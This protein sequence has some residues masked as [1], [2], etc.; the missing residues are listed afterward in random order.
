MSIQYA[1]GTN[2]SS[3]IAADDRPTLAA[4]LIAELVAA[5]WS[6]DVNTSATDKTLL[7]ATTPQSLNI[8]VR[9]YDPGSGSCARLKMSNAAGTR[10]QAGDVFLLVGAGKT[11]RVIANKY[12]FFCFTPGSTACREFAAGGTPYLPSFLSG[13]ITECGWLLGNALSDGDTAAVTATTQGVLRAGLSF[14]GAG[15]QNGNMY[16]LCNGSAVE[17]NVQYVSTVSM[18]PC[19]GLQVQGGPVAS[20]SGHLRSYRWHD[21][22]LFVYEPL[23]GWGLTNVSESKLRGQLWDGMIVSDSFAADFTLSSFDGHNWWAITS[24]NPG[25]DGVQ[26]RG[27][28]FLVVP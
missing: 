13:V 7:S 28:L 11:Y 26:P 14:T 5:G 21:D 4:A 20:S 24:S 3:S 6:V 23:V 10:T 22:S 19:P 2:R 15:T 18:A 16:L 1:G 8:R 25:T 12:Q 9:V 17:Y 27:T